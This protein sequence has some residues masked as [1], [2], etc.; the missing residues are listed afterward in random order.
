MVFIVLYN[1][2]RHANKCKIN[3]KK[4]QWEKVYNPH[5]KLS[6][7]IP[8]K[9]ELHLTAHALTGMRASDKKRMDDRRYPIQNH[10]CE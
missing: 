9:I 7:H 4:V 1:D 2:Y 8:N 10:I 6:T 5:V 3:M